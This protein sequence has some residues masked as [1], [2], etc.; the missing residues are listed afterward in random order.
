MSKR[1]SLVISHGTID[2]NVDNFYNFVVL[3]SS[4]VVGRWGFRP[5]LRLRHMMEPMHMTNQLITNRALDNGLVMRNKTMMGLSKSFRFFVGAVFVILWMALTLKFPRTHHQ[6]VPLH[7]PPVKATA[8]FGFQAKQLEHN[9][10]KKKKICHL[11]QALTSCKSQSSN[12]I[13]A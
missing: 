6:N 8:P 2:V 10:Q 12:V 11:M 5:R 9:V 13:T 1:K 7:L 3:F 4:I